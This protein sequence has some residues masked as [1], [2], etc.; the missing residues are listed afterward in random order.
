MFGQDGGTK[1][2]V[3]ALP[4]RTREPGGLQSARAQ[5]RYFIALDDRDSPGNAIGYAS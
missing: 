1:T 5:Y 3:A 4:Y 2:E